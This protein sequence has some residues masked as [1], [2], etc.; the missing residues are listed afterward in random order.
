MP[1][2]TDSRGLL[3]RLA[4]GYDGSAVRAAAAGVARRARSVARTAGRWVRGSWLYRW[5]TAEPDPEVIVIDLRETYTVGPFVRLLDRIVP[6]I[7]SVVRNSLTWRFVVRTV[8][9]VERVVERSSLLQRVGAALAPPE[10]PATQAARDPDDEV[11]EA[12]DA[13]PERTENRDASGGE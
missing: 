10:P 4:A 2:E 11:G 7:A 8:D 13:S 12:E 1:G 9:A 6:P 5:L 3:D